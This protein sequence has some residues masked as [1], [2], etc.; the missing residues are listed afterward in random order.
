VSASLSSRLATTLPES[1]ASPNVSCFH[2]GLPV[3]ST[4]TFSVLWNGRYQ[5]TCCVGCEAVATMI[6]DSGMDDFYRQRTGY[7]T[8]PADLLPIQAASGF[9]AASATLNSATKTS[10][11]AIHL[12]LTNLTC[13]ACVWLA[14]KTLSRLAGVSDVEVN[15]TTHS[16]RLVADNPDADI[17][18]RALQRVGLEAERVDD[19]SRDAN[20]QLRRRK[21]LINFGVASLSMMQVMMLTVP[22]YFA[23]PE[24]ISTDARHLMGWAAWLMTIPALIFSA[25]PIFIAAWRGLLNA[26]IGMD[27]PVAIALALTFFASSWALMTQQGHLYFDAITMFIFLLLGARWIES[28]TRERAVARIERMSNPKPITVSRLI[29]F[30]N[31][32]A[33]EW[34]NS[35]SLCVDQIIAIEQGALI[36]ADGE[37]LRGESEVD[38]ALMSGESKPVAKRVG[39]HV[40]GGTLNMIGAIVV[41][42]TAVGKRSVL[43]QLARLVDSALL[44]RPSFHGITEKVARYLAPATLLLALIGA[45][46]WAMID[47]SKS[48]DVAV[49][50]LAITCPCA[51]A[52]AA[53]TAA[54]ATLGAMASRG[55]LVVRGHVLETLAT[56]TDVVFDKTGTITTGQWRLIEISVATTERDFYLNICGALESGAIHPVARA[57]QHELAAQNSHATVPSELVATSLIQVAGSGVEGVI[58]GQ[59]YR[60]GTHRFALGEDKLASI[61]AKPDDTN[62]TTL[63]SA[64]RGEQ[65]MPLA[66]L[67]FKD[68]IRPNVSQTIAKLEAAGL[69][70]HLLSGDATNVVNAVA[71]TC[72]INIDRVRATQSAAEKRDYVLA[73]Q[74]QGRRVVAIG[75]GMNDAPMLASADAGIGLAAGASLTRLSS[76]AVLDEG[77]LQ[78]FTCIGDAFMRARQTLVITRQNI[79][80]AFFYNAVA[81]PLAFCALVT[82]FIAAV[83]M[84]LSSLVVVINATRLG[85][86]NRSGY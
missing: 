17:F 48:L 60:F 9:A 37:I 10:A 13:A 29:D 4:S 41:R 27:L 43:A 84:A 45:L 57:I 21:Q 14:E 64:Q 54:A 53:P 6:I 33:N 24:D 61:N 58:D 25:R 35:Q 56:A 23:S 73:L 52:L 30:P 18:I 76:D 15:F 26:H 65:W 19:T 46:A 63:L 86:W 70:V 16:A 79:G 80:W 39:D 11:E 50:I 69:N 85:S 31:S 44:A 36:P 59:R 32:E 81:L 71:R 83:G 20:R 7:S 49:A 68:E 62:T 47:A 67:T 22:L 55:L 2:C 8:K 34:V 28:A 82:P 78:L 40:R 3:D 38:E 74:A 72:G 5:P 75:D 77:K 42:V 12:Y 51:F 66:T 1:A